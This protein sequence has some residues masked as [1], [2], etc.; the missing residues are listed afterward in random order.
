MKNNPV[1]KGI[2]SENFNG[3][4]PVSRKMV[5][6]R[7]SELAQIGG[8]LPQSISQADYEQAKRELTGES[9]I[10][11]QEAILDSLPESKRWDPVPGSTGHE[12]PGAE[13]EDMDDEGRSE[14]EQLV[15][16]GVEEADHDQMLQAAKAT[17]GNDR[18]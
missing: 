1:N 12:T 17:L 7:A 2:I 13:S 11:S 4:G 3:I 18:P 16:Q 5:H 15:E 14:S 9:D 8:R 6:E 10:D